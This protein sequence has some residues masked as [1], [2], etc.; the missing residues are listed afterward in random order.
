MNK[1]FEKSVQVRANKKIS[2]GYVLD[3][4]TKLTLEDKKMSV[5]S[6]QEKAICH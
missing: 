2:K 5:L 4:D 1:I 3:T 6:L